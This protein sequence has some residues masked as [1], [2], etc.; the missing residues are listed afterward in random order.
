M[1]E[2]KIAELKA[3]L[4]GYLSEVRK[5]ETIIVCD[6][7]TPIARISSIAHTDDDDLIVEEALDPPAK[8][9]TIKPLKR[10]KDIDVDAVLAEMRADRR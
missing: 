4:S 3:R 9:R 8:A 6:R 7:T 5:G 1:K 2:V 10:L